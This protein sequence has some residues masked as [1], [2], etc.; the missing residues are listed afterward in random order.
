MGD[1]GCVFV[2]LS[3][4]RRSVHVPGSVG[5]VSQ[6]MALADNNLLVMGPMF[7]HT[8][9]RYIYIYIGIH[10]CTHMFVYK[11][12]NTWCM[13]MKIEYQRI[14]T[15]AGVG[16]SLGVAVPLSA[17]Q[18]TALRQVRLSTS[19]WSSYFAQREAQ[20]GLIW[21]AAGEGMEETLH[22]SILANINQACFS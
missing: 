15:A 1:Q 10:I 8:H 11:H 14:L 22:I 9:I 6:A 21:D 7:T 20:C 2:A 3:F 13:S 18:H 17:C 12:T 4:F 19:A 16:K 5:I